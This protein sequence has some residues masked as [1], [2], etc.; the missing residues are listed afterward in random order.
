MNEERGSIVDL[1]VWVF[2]LKCSFFVY[3]LMCVDRVRFQLFQ[4]RIEEPP[5]GCR[6]GGGVSY[7]YQGPRGR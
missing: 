6:G 4:W 7:V 3:R 2:Y 5:K 1:R